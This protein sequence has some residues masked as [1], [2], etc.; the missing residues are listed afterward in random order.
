MLRQDMK[1]SRR[2]ALVAVATSTAAVA[3][4]GE[5]AT[6]LDRRETGD[7]AL[8]DVLSRLALVAEVVYPSQVQVTESFLRIHLLGN[9]YD[10]EGYIER[11]AVALDELDRQARR[12]FDEP[13]ADLSVSK[14]DRLLRQLGVDRVPADPE[15]TAVERIRYYVVNK[16]LFT[17]YTSPTGGRLLGNENPPGYPGGREAYQRGPTDE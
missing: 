11:T 17:L 1:L 15:G 4:A 8:D 10:R 5:F 2:D 16:L 7:E 13:V 6:R 9:E 14:C 12:R 3:T